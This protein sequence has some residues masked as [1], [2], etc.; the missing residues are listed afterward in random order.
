MA[1]D[2][3]NLVLKD[4]V[5]KSGLEFSLPGRC[6][7]DIA[8]LL[9]S[10]K[11]DEILPCGDGGRVEGGIGL[12]GLEGLEG[13]GFDELSKLVS[14]RQNYFQHISCLPWRTCPWMR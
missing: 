8:S 3:S 6:G 1:S 10:S 14:G 4:L 12:V 5:E 7:G 2:A 13:V 11:D 9:S